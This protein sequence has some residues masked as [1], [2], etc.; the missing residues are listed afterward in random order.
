MSA[1]ESARDEKRRPLPPD[2]VLNEAVARLS[3]E[4]AVQT[5]VRGTLPLDSLRRLVKPNFPKREAA[6]LPP[7]VWASMGA[8][9]I[10]R[11]LD[12]G[13]GV[14]QALHDRLG[15]DRD[16][17]LDELEQM[18]PDRPLEALWNAA[19]SSQKDVRKAFPR[20]AEECVGAYRRSPACVPPTWDF[21]EA[22][23][24]EQSRT[25]DEL[26]DW[27]ADAEDLKKHLESERDRLQE[28]RDELKKLRRENHELRSERA[29]FEKRLQEAV[30]AVAA[31]APAAPSEERLADLEKK[32]RRA[33]KE[34]EHLRRKLERALAIDEA[35]KAA[36]AEAGAA[37]EADE[38]DADD[39]E[40]EADASLP[41]DH[42][43]TIAA[44]PNPKRRVIRQ[45]LRKLVSKGKIGG[46]HTHEDNVFRGVADHE[47]G[48]AKDAIDL[49]YREGVLMPKTTI[50]DPHVS[51]DPERMPEVHALIAGDFRNERVRRFT[52][53]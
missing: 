29:R 10:E 49:L 14:L 24:D 16:A 36:A 51:I 44:D 31:A 26:E 40:A 39:D 9:L 47:K 15:W 17:S 33:E 50:A 8:S 30:G 7:E 11:S 25:A 52:E 13:Y 45:M 38:G 21:V 41:P 53:S 32:L 1:Q 23:L 6:E 18:A 28:L 27:A 35:E 48:I 46:A 3:K 5:L 43:S 2:N 12:W 34:N 42:P 22:V 4:R 20:L 19:L 37:I